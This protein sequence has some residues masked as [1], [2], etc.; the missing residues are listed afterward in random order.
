MLLNQ[1]IQDLTQFYGQKA[2]FTQC[3]RNRQRQGVE[4]S[5]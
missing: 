2:H 1:S 5:A 3:V 4:P